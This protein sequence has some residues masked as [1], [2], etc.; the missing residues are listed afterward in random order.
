VA[1]SLAYWLIGYVLR[2]Y[3][4]DT[5]A[6]HTSKLAVK[7]IERKKLSLP[8]RPRLPHLRRP[9]DAICLPFISHLTVNSHKRKI[10]L[11][12]FAWFFENIFVGA[13]KSSRSYA[14]VEIIISYQS[15]QHYP[16]ISLPWVQPIQTNKLTNK[17]VWQL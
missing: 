1:H 8:L 13:C 4:I 14:F 11:T 15:S 6:K 12:H 7:K 17:T 3:L 9:T 5:G 16:N 2:P 10:L